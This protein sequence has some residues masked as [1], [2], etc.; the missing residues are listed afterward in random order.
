M[1]GTRKSAGPCRLRITMNKLPGTTSI[2]NKISA[3]IRPADRPFGRL[4]YKMLRLAVVAQPVGTLEVNGVLSK[5]KPETP[6]PSRRR[7][8]EH[9]R[10]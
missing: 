3:A 7:W 8:A 6:A 9:S 1:W 10:R 4:P 2:G 5:R